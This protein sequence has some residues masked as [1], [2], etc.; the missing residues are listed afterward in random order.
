MA[1]RPRFHRA[2]LAW[3]QAS[4]HRFVLQPHLL[5]RDNL[6]LW[7]GFDQATPSIEVEVCRVPPSAGGPWEYR[8]QVWHSLGW[9]H[10]DPYLSLSV[11]VARA[12]DI[13]A[14]RAPLAE[15]IRSA[16][17]RVELWRIFLFEPF[18]DF[19]NGTLARSTAIATG[20][21]RC[22]PMFVGDLPQEETPEVES[23]GV[24]LHTHWLVGSGNEAQDPN[25]R[26]DH[27]EPIRQEQITQRH[28]R[29]SR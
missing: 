18:L 14:G 12:G 22:Q 11:Q 10:L 3:L 25:L 16:A 24:W 15:E 28:Q 6:R 29:R 8:L 21:V 17:D 4:R 20:M 27:L 2:F 5:R 19:V 7:L 9:L 1:V 23:D 26:I 13:Q